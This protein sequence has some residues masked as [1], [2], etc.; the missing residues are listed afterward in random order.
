MSDL[1][2]P[3]FILHFLCF[4]SPSR[5]QALGLFGS[6]FLINLRSFADGTR[7]SQTFYFTIGFFDFFQSRARSFLYN[8]PA[9]SVAIVGRWQIFAPR[10]AANALAPWP[11]VS[12]FLVNFL[13]VPGFA[14]T[15]VRIFFFQTLASLTLPLALTR[16]VLISLAGR[17]LTL[18]P[19]TLAS[20]ILPRPLT[21]LT[22]PPLSLT[23]RLLVL[24]LRVLLWLRRFVFLIGRRNIDC[25]R[26]E[27]EGEHDGY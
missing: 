19:W 1:L 21:A 11:L 9:A 5:S 26:D 14:W 16:W 20:R 8:F 17:I 23:A 27:R 12:R 25:R 10:C 18:A 3:V 22:L 4:E 15:L 6:A 24:P 2:C 7:G 13:V